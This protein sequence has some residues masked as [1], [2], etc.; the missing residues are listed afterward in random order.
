MTARRRTLAVATLGVAFMALA[1]AVAGLGDLRV[2]NREYVALQGG[3]VAVCGLAALLLWRRARRRD[4][5]LVLVVALAARALLAF[6]VPTLSDDAYRFV[7][8]GRVQAEGINPYRHTPAGQGVRHLRDW[9]VFTEVNRPYTR[10][11]Y[12]PADQLAFRAAHAV[13]GDGVVRVKLFLLAVEAAVV[14]LLLVLLARTGRSPGRVALY[15]WHPLAVVEIASSGH[16][17]PLLLAL[18]LAALLL[19]DARRRVSAG[20]ALGA[21]A[22]TKFVPLVL[23]PF[24]LR[25]GGWRLAAAAAVTGL[26]LYLPYAGAG[27]LVL[28]SVGSYADEQFGAGL[29]RWL[30][31]VGLP[32]SPVRVLLLAGLASGVLWSA[33]R[34]PSD[35]AGACRYAALLLGGALLASHNVQPWYLLWVLPFLCVAPFSGLLWATATVSL[36]YLV[37]KPHRVVDPDVLSLVVWAPALAL[38]AGAAIRSSFLRPAWAGARVQEPAGEQAPAAA[39]RGRAEMERARAEKGQLPSRAASSG[40]S[41]RPPACA[42]LEPTFAE[43]SSASSDPSA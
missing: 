33:L 30:T 25:R 13:A 3:M 23:A 14:A 27:A 39:A 17:E 37:M 4:V 10:T 16:L 11:V 35:L 31:Y 20:A 43:S 19:W 28:G 40:A 21:A 38:L 26:L 5:V 42:P 8:D 22:L 41:S 18:T 29:F 34:P 12:P 36:F 24:L 32:E 2:H 15:V 1:A 7:W 6:D 9:E